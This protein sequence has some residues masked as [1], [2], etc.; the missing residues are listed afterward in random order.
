M[1]GWCLATNLPFSSSSS[2]IGNS[3]THNRL[4]WLGSARPNLSAT[5]ILTWPKASY[6]TGSLSATNSSRSPDLASIAPVILANSSSVK[7]FAI[8]EVTPS[9]VIF[10]Q[11]RPLALYVFAWSSRWLMAFLVKWSAPPTTFIPLTELPGLVESENTLKP[12]SATIS[13]IFTN[14]N[15]YLVSGLS[16]PYL[17]MASA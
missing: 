13:D 1:N 6:T 4:N 14:S 10:I 8:G 17:S 12:Q 15:P 11:A 7:N 2:N 5:A 3:V 16:D 9:S